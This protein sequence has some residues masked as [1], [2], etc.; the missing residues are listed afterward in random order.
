[1]RYQWNPWQEMRRLQRDMNDVLDNEPRSGSPEVGWQPAVDIY[2]EVER[3][4]VTV[5]A[6]GIDPEKVEV[7]VEDNHLTLR[8]SRELEFED[9]KEN[10]HR[11]ERDYGIFTRTFS[12]PTTVEAEKIVAEYKQGLLRITI[13]KRSEVLPKKITVRVTE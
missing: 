9:R 6:P 10:Y 13:P 11:L 5:E 4:L 3:F 8:G 1:M 2:E 12:L 7:R